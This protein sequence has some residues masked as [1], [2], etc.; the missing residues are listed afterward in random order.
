LA[1]LSSLSDR[2]LSS[3]GRKGFMIS[4]MLSNQL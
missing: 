1:K 2:L 4:R 3:G